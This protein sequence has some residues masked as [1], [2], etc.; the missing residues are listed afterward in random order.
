MIRTK[1]R[2]DGVAVRHDAASKDEWHIGCIVG[3]KAAQRQDVRALVPID[4][5]TA[6]S[7]REVPNRVVGELRVA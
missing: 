3:C 1:K 5:N 7:C 6:G 2:P 4:P